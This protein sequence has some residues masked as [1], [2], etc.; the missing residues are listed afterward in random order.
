MDLKCWKYLE[1]LQIGNFCTFYRK[2]DSSYFGHFHMHKAKACTF[3]LRNVRRVWKYLKTVESL[4]WKPV[5]GEYAGDIY[6]DVKYW[7]NDIH[8]MVEIPPTS[9]FNLQC[10]NFF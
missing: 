3:T 9:K 6:Q 8:K 2:L 1:F 7:L 10:S 5:S 4:N